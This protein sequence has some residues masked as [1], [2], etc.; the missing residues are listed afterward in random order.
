MKKTSLLVL[1]IVL[2]IAFLWQAYRQNDEPTQMHVTGLTMGTIVYNVKYLGSTN[3]FKS[4]IDQVL[5]EFNQS[6]STYI[7]DSEISRLNADGQLNFES[8][9]FLPVLRTSKEVFFKTNGTFDPS[10]G[11][12]V[13]AWGFG[14]NK[15]IPEMD[16]AK[17]DSLKKVIGFDRVVFDSNSASLPEN[18]QLDFSAIA[19]GYA[20]DLV[21]ELLEV[22]KIENYMVEI[23]GEVRSKGLNEKQETWTLGIEDPT[24]NRDERRLYAIARLKDRSLATSGNYRNYYEK[25]GRTY[26][27]IIDPRTGYNAK[28]DL[29]S[30]SVF[31]QNC[32]TAD[33]Y[34]TAFMVLGIDSSM[35][36][37][38]NDS[39]LDAIF[40]YQNDEGNLESLVSNGIKPF[41]EVR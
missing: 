29:L 20:V 34:S 32:M 36:I 10:I 26:A 37:V 27:H 22:E 7:P 9:Y 19:K 3:D 41:V 16:R 17:I 5:A 39:D 1:G 28:H 38:E 4:E 25:D 12:L 33:A 23:G 15:K 14:P 24:V 13:Q 30:V 8:R 18:Y 6:L 40:I 21:A 11:P 2:V 31:A 35:A